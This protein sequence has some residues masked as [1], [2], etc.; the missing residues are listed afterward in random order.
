MPSVGSLT[1][2][3]SCVVN[4]ISDMALLVSMLKILSRVGWYA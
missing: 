4:E 3:E 2:G 1:A